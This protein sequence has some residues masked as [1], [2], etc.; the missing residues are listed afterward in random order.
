MLLNLFVF[1]NQDEDLGEAELKIAKESS[2]AAHAS[3]GG[4]RRVHRP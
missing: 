3:G 4:W 1:A 2:M